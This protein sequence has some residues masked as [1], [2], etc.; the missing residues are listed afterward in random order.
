MRGVVFG[1][2]A[3][4]CLLIRIYINENR[5]SDNSIQKRGNIR[6][7]NISY[8][9]QI[10]YICRKGL[11]GWWGGGGGQ[12]NLRTLTFLKKKKLYRLQNE[13]YIFF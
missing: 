4:V 3:L 6:K 11:V 7:V 13:Y 12:G 1:L 9:R 5:S 8:D 10:M 2:S